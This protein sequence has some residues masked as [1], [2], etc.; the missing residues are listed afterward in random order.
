[1]K[2]PAA[3]PTIWGLNYMIA[4]THGPRR[5]SYIGVLMVH[6]RFERPEEGSRETSRA[7]SITFVQLFCAL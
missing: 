6:S 4:V 2:Q 3:V 5:Q 7:L 1:M